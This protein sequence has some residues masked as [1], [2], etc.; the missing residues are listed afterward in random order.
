M[1][2]VIACEHVCS[3]DC[4]REGCNCQCG[5][6]HQEAVTLTVQHLSS[7]YNDA[8]TVDELL[9]HIGG[10]LDFRQLPDHDEGDRTAAD[11]A[12]DEPFVTE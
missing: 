4:R 9:A 2:K 8:P 12:D 3:G 11:Y 6:F 5:E 1:N 7:D 10:E